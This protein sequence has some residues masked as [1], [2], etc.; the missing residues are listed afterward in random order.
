MISVYRTEK[1]WPMRKCPGLYGITTNWTLSKK[2]EDKNSFSGLYSFLCHPLS[3][4]LLNNIQ[5]HPSCL[6]VASIQVSETPSRYQETAGR[7]SQPPGAHSTSRWRLPGLQ[8]YTRVLWRPFWG[9][10]WSDVSTASSDWY[11]SE[12]E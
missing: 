1:I 6:F 10:P 7:G 3:I 5:T 4:F 12:I 9:F 11:T 2:K 8:S